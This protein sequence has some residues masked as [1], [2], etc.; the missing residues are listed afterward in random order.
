MNFDDHIFD[1]SKKARGKLKALARIAPFIGL[2]KRRI[3]ISPF[4]NPQFS[5]CLLICMCYSR[6]NNRKINRIHERCSVFTNKE[7]QSKLLEFLQMDDSAFIHMRNIKSRAIEMLRDN[8]NLSRPVMNDFHA[9]G[10]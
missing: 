9:K 10:Q 8:R 5:C 6:T 4:F 2:S 7:K 3:L 1:I